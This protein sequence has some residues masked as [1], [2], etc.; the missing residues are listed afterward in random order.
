[1]SKKILIVDDEPELRAILKEVAESLSFHVTESINGE[2]GLEKSLQ[3]KPDLIISDVR[4][5]KKDGLSFLKDYRK[6]KL[7]TPFFIMTAFDDVSEHQVYLLQGNGIFY[8]PL[9]LDAMNE[10]F[11]K[12]V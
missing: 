2:D 11:L 4:M 12:Y 6:L 10:F 1:M 8:K 3:I 5:P 9:N 7:E